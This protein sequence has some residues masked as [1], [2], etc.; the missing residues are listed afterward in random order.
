MALYIKV[1]DN[2]WQFSFGSKYMVIA[3]VLADASTPYTAGGT[4][5]LISS[6]DPEVKAARA[7]WFSVFVGQGGL[8]ASYIPSDYPPPAGKS[9]STVL[10]NANSGKLQIFLNGVEIT[11]ADLSATLLP[12]TLQGMMIF[13]G[14]E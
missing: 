7:P 9:P 4:P 13:Q 6:R 8:T 10:G 14:M 2:R 11:S 1:R 3:D 12:G 5:L